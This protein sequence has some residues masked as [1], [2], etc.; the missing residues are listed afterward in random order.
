MYQ[1]LIIDF[2]LAVKKFFKVFKEF[3]LKWMEHERGYKT[4]VAV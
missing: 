2:V 1:F 3:L 4:L